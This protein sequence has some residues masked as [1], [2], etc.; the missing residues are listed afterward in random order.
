M[1]RWAPGLSAVLVAVVAVGVVATRGGADA[2]ASRS[3]SAPARLDRLPSAVTISLPGRATGKTVPDGFLGF[4]FEFQAV[5]AYT[6]SDP[7]HINPVLKQLIRNLSPGQAPVLRIG[8]NSTDVSYVPTPGVPD[9]PYVGYALTP[10]WLATTGALAHELG[11]RMT[12]GLNL[13]ANKPSLA[14][15]EGRAFLRAI[16]SGN[17]QAFEIGN[18]PNLYRGATIYHTVA[19]LP[20]HARPPTFGY[21]AFRSQ[22]EAIA[23]AAPRLPLAGPALAAGPK[24][25]SGSWVTTMPDFLARDPRVQTMTV[26]R[27]PLRN[28]YVPPSSPQ[29]PTIDHL[30]ARY[31][32]AGLAGSLHRW[33]AIAH[34]QHRRLRVDELNS[35]ACRGQTG[36]SDTF[37]SSLWATDALFSLLDAGAD[38]VNL[39]TLPGSAYELFDFAHDRQGWHGWVRPVYYGLELFAEAAPPG[40]RLLTIGG[41]AAGSSV[42]SIWGT[43]SRDGIDRVVLIDKDPNRPE[44]VTVRPPHGAPRGATLERMQAPSVHSAGSITLG[45]RTYGSSTDTGQLPPPV[46]QALNPGRHGG[47]TVTV[48]PGSAALLTLRPSS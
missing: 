22:F 2:P 18:E 19:G 12:M 41:I 16:G 44:K 40:A 28:C 1:R 14:A 25:M 21:P 38:G 37:A 7:R 34:H 24:P 31:A 30:L 45:G 11:A 36:V 35:V 9:P 47:Y 42:L 8:G 33:L 20:V 46:T 29:Y 23:R 6:G 15:A 5:R 10:G 3:P 43:R 27:Y 17:L 39:H 48:P 26:H 4:S 13:A 32:T